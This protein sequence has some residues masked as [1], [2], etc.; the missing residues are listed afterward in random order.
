M[1]RECE[2]AV[3]CF[4]CADESSNP[5]ANLSA[6]DPD[7]NIFLSVDFRRIPNPP[8]NNWST[9][10][11]TAFC[12]SSISQEDADD[13][14][15]RKTFDCIVDAPPPNPD[16]PSWPTPTYCNPART[17]ESGP[18]CYTIP[19]GTVC[20]FSAIEAD[21]I[22]QS[23]CNHRVHD[24]ELTSACSSAPPPAPTPEEPCPAEAGSPAP[25]SLEISSQQ[26]W[27]IHPIT[28]A[29]LSPAISISPPC[30]P[31]E[32]HI[33]TPTDPVDHPPGNY[34][35][36][37]VDGYY[38]YTTACAIPETPHQGAVHVF[39]LQNEEYNFDS[40]P[41]PPCDRAYIANLWF[42][43]NFSGYSSCYANSAAAQ[44][45]ITAVFA[46]RVFRTD[47]Y[48]P[49]EADGFP[50]S[51]NGGDFSM[52]FDD[53]ALP[54]NGDLLFPVGPMRF[55]VVQIEGLIPQPRKVAISNYAA[56][57]SQFADPAAAA[58]WN[59]EFPERTVYTSMTVQWAVTAAGAFGGAV[60]RWTD[61]HPTTANGK[62]FMLEIFSDGAIL[63]WRG[64]RGVGSTPLGQ[65]DKD[66]TS[67]PIGPKCIFC[68]DN[69]DQPWQPS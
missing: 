51:N 16:N 41:P 21:A 32:E 15:R 20:A 59:G 49:D 67:T 69:S 1:V 44:A 22:A 52:M 40:P 26:L 62:G 50:H 68:E 7:L 29:V 30:N 39:K 54:I 33:Y 19:S 60:L 61:A 57:I 64:F 2:R 42:P 13:C 28:T 55:Q 65:F 45:D 5:F 11:C 12:E 3:R 8:H 43:G 53:N 47:P 25:D 23:L 48:P 17:C 14:A 10:I 18:N 9:N 36:I 63:M 66:S 58:S 4:P 46:G 24:P 31:T 35:L 37:Y 38:H 6:E 27:E 34:G 56:L